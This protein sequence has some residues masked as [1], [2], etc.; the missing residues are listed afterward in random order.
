[1]LVAIANGEPSGNERTRQIIETEREAARRRNRMIA[2]FIAE[3]RIEA[4]RLRTR[5]IL[6]EHR[7]DMV[8]QIAEIRAMARSQSAIW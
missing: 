1:M 4:R 3:A 6:A 2:G 7:R 8:Q 5:K